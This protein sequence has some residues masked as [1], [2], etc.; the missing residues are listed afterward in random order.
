MK[1]KFIVI[2]K[3][4]LFDYIYMI[5]FEIYVIG[6]EDGLVVIRSWELVKR[7]M[8]KGWYKVI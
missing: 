1:E 4:I 2:D 3:Y 8:I 6:M 7:L 5:F